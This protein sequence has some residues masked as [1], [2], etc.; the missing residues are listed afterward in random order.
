MVRTEKDARKW[1]RRNMKEGGDGADEIF[2]GFVYLRGGPH[3]HS[4]HKK[5]IV[6]EILFILEIYI[7]RDGSGSP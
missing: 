1:F 6:D 7:E 4:T 5:L 3:V 2:G